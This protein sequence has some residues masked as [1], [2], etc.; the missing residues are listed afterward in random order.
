VDRHR[1]VGDALATGWFWAE[2]GSGFF[3]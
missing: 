3:L 1:S 2:L